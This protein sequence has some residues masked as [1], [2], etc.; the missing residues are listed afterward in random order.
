MTAAS[1]IRNLADGKSQVVRNGRTP[2]WYARSAGVLALPTELVAFC[3][4]DD[5]WLPRC[6]AGSGAGGPGRKPVRELRD[7]RGL[8]QRQPPASRP[9]R[10]RTRT[11]CGRD[12]DGAPSAFWPAGPPLPATSG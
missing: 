11:C 6:A 7:H 9:R 2:G 5:E 4:D 12:G 1:Q 8:H 10:G 3:D